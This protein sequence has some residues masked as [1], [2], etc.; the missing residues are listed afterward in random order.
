MI[1]AEDIP[2]FVQLGL[3]W[4]ISDHQNF[5]QLAWTVILRLTCSHQVYILPCLFYFFITFVGTGKLLLVLR[6]H[7]FLC[8]CVTEC[9]YSVAVS[10]RSIL[11]CGLF[12]SITCWLS[13]YPSIWFND[14]AV[15]SDWVHFMCPVGEICL[16]G[17]RQL[18]Q[19]VHYKIIPYK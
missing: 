16:R 18:Q 19:T 13:V 12:L 8:S 4:S 11:L 15:E 2:L 6:E 1:R 14:A 17:K 9:G 3:H 5:Q 7:M 10:G